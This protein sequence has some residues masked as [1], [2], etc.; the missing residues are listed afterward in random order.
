MEGQTSRATNP[1]IV[2]ADMNATA[3]RAEA[4]GRMFSTVQ[5]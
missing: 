3:K 2:L 4:V 1:A 5:K